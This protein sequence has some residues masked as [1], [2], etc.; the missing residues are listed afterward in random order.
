[1]SHKRTATTDAKYNS[2]LSYEKKTAWQVTS[3]VVEKPELSVWM[4]L[5]PIV[6]IP[7]MQRYQKYKETS[8]EFCD[9]YLFTKKI[10][11]DTALKM[12]K[13][14][15]TEEEAFLAVSEA[16]AD[17]P[18][19]DARVLKIYEKQVAEINLL[20][21][22]YLALLSS[23]GDD[24]RQLVAGHYQSYE[25]YT[26]FLHQLMAAEKEVNRAATLTF[27][28]DTEEVPDIIESMEKC[29]KELRFAEAQKY[30]SGT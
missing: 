28:A 16:V 2:I 30:F 8:K 6:F 26:A 13:N 14:T 29:L 4:I 18:K 5:I 3:K 24:Y 10:A 1:M 9:G 12:H 20:C 23:Q 25:N 21:H 27:K 7:Y 15:M 17:N 11:L 19:A 22:H